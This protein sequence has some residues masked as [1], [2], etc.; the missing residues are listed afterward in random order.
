MHRV[1]FRGGGVRPPAQNGWATTPSEDRHTLLPKVTGR[2]EGVEDA[3]EGGASDGIPERVVALAN[4][5]GGLLALKAPPQLDEGGRVCPKP[6]AGVEEHC[7][8]CL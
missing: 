6:Y 4:R 2:R 7:W 3:V 1:R 8:V 5:F